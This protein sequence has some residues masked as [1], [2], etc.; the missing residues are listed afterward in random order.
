VMISRKIDELII[1]RQEVRMRTRNKGKSEVSELTKVLKLSDHT[2]SMSEEAI[3]TRHISQ[4]NV[5]ICCDGI[6]EM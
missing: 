6:K 1:S 4:R 3:E 2:E 5:G